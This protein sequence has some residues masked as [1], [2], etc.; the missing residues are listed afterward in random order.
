MKNP[1]DKKAFFEKYRQM[2]RSQKGLEGA[3]EWKTLKKLLPDF[4]KKSVLDLGCG[5]GWHCLYAAEH[6]AEKVIDID[7]SKKMLAVAREKTQ[8]IK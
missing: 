1:Y 6:G 3:G 7:L 8:V 5:Y 4:E 2:T